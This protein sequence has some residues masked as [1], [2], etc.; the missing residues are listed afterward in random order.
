MNVEQTQNDKKKVNKPF[1]LLVNF[2]RVPNSNCKKVREI[3]D[4]P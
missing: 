1:D 2:R 4:L 3:E